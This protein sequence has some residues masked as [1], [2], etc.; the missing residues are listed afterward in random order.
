MDHSASQRDSPPAPQGLRN[1]SK[2]SFP[3]CRHPPLTSLDAGAMSPPAQPNGC[4]PPVKA[5]CDC[6]SV[7]GATQH[8]GPAGPQKLPWPGLPVSAGQRAPGGGRSVPLA[9]AG[10][11]IT[12]HGAGG[13]VIGGVLSARVCGSTIVSIWGRCRSVVSLSMPLSVS[14]RQRLSCR[15]VSASGGPSRSLVSSLLASFRACYPATAR[16]CSALTSMLCCFHSTLS[17]R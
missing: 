14:E 3:L 12:H 11:L 15:A 6:L 8:P 1:P 9:A 5:A 7:D 13:C 16:G 10:E 2:S 4:F 17:P